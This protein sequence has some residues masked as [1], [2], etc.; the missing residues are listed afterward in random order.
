MTGMITLTGVTK[1]FGTKEVLKGV[2]LD[3]P[4]GQSV[5]VI[6]G[7]G[8][9]KSVMLK[10]ILGLLTPDAGTIHI[11]GMQTVGLSRTERAPIDAKMGMLFQ[12]GALFDSLPVWRNVAFR[13]L[14][15]KT[16][17]MD[18]ARDVAAASLAQV[19]LGSELLDLSPSSLSGGMQKRVGLARAIASKPDIIFFDE[20]TTGLDPI[21]TDVIN[22]LIRDCVRDL[23][24][25][26]LTI[27]HDM[28]SV[29]AI[30]DKTALLYQGRII[31]QGTTSELEKSDD[32]FL[33]QFI[34]GL[35]HG[36]IEVEGQTLDVAA[37]GGA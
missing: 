5:V 23:G 1:A 8:S 12:N 27:T 37:G 7:S 20:P 26:T 13:G 15:D 10:S 31:W 35:A 24:A 18:A 2:D 28:T 9:G 33:N 4:K 34:N 16:L 32:P 6:G 30:A 22:H 11:D 25:T 21:M 17:E 19:G 3:I 29:R 36:P 14:Q